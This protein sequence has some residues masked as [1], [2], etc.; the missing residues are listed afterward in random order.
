MGGCASLRVRQDYDTT[1]DFTR[2]KTYDWIHHDINNA[3]VDNSLTND[4][5]RK[6]ADN[7]LKV[8]GYVK[9]TTG[10]VDFLVDY[11]YSITRES[12]TGNSTSLGL[13]FSGGFGGGFGLGVGQNIE[14]DETETLG[15]AVIDPV[16]NKLMWR[17]FVQQGYV[18]HTDPNRAARDIRKTVEEILTRFPPVKGLK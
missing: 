12:Q 8:I 10:T 15:I 13:G 2:L 14:Q 5:I 7:A 9:K 16:T 3:S 18:R 1:V 11:D 4:R 6:A 17:G